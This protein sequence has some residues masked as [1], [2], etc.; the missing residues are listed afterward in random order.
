MSGK[1]YGQTVSYTCNQ[2]YIL[3]GATT[4]KCE[5]NGWSNSPP[6]CKLQG[7]YRLNT[8]DL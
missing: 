1:T 4:L 2:G 3:D 5:E 8:G 7:N 6:T